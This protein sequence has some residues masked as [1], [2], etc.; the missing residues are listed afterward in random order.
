MSKEPARGIPS[1]AIHD[2]LV[3]AIGGSEGR[4]GAATESLLKATHEFLHH[5]G[6]EL[7]RLLQLKKTKT[8][9]EED[10]KF[11]LSE[12]RMACKVSWADV[13][14]AKG[15]PLIKAAPA[16]REFNKGFGDARTNS[17]AKKALAAIAQAYAAS[18][19]RRAALFAKAGGRKGIKPDDIAKAMA[20]M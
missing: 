8:V 5:A 17:E 16:V 2:I 18:V 3:N 4:A 14:A 12:G 9:T 19:A 15:N 6:A 7:K 1:K 10:L 13:A 20:A 11:Y